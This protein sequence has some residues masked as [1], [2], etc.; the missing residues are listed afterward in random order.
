MIIINSHEEPITEMSFMLY[1]AKY[2]DNPECFDTEEFLSDL[3]RF[4]YIKRL[5]NKYQETGELKERLILN[6]II[7]LYNVFGTPAATRMLFF[8][9]DEFLPYLKSFL[10]FLGYTPDKVSNIGF[11]SK[12]IYCDTIVSDEQINKALY[13]I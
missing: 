11:E 7:I 10:D 1:A 3:K 5:L 12:T 8:R 4:K 9:L 13:L 2:Y 6:H